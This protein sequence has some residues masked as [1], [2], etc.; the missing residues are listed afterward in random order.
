MQKSVSHRGRLHSIT[1]T[2]DLIHFIKC[3]VSISFGFSDSTM[4]SGCWN[5]LKQV[6]FPS[7][8]FEAPRE[9]NRFCLLR[10][11]R[12]EIAEEANCGKIRW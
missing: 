2:L 3:Q 1:R 8:N 11:E 12:R 4:E 5:E 9:S 10:G 6:S 7:E